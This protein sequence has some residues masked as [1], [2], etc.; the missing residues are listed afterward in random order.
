MNEVFNNLP[1]YTWRFREFDT[2]SYC[3]PVP[4]LLALT[5]HKGKEDELWSSMPYTTNALYL[6][7]LCYGVGFIFLTGLVKLLVTWLVLQRYGCVMED[8]AYLTYYPVGLYSFGRFLLVNIGAYIITGTVCRLVNNRILASIMLVLAEFVPLMLLVPIRWVTGQYW[9][10]L[11]QFSEVYSI[12]SLGATSSELNPPIRTA[13]TIIYIAV[14]LIMLV[15][16]LYINKQR[17][18]N[19]KTKLFYNTAVK[20]VYIVFCVLF[21]LNVIETLFLQGGL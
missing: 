10:A 16:D 1:F 2:V 18:E 13:G 7:R 12:I 3:L 5:L 6:I 9:D 14:I 19:G 21:L 17:S 4:I 20:V 8:M 11:S 15:L